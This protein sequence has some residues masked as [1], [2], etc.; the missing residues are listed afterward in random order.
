MDKLEYLRSIIRNTGYPLEIQISALLDKRWDVVLNTD[1][2]YDREEEKLR[3]IDIVTSRT[4]FYQGT[5]VT[6][7]TGIVIECKKTEKYAW[8]FFTRPFSFDHT[9]VAGQYL[10]KIQCVTNNL[11]KSNFLDEI[12]FQPELMHYAD[13]K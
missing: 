8:V 6:L 13:F 7:Q 3:D 5:N 1:S 12:L 10:D 4:H 11:E 9:E 2:Y